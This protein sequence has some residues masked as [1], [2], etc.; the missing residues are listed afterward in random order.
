M[1]TFVDGGVSGVESHVGF[2]VERFA[3]RE[4]AAEIFHRAIVAMPLRG[5]RLERRRGP[6][7]LA[8]F[9]LIQTV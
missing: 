2:T 6:C 3:R 5:N 9:A 7:V 1:E 8:G 4:N